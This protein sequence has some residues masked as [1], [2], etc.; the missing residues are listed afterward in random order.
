MAALGKKYSKVCNDPD[1]TDIVQPYMWLGI[2]SSSSQDEKRYS[3]GIKI[4]RIMINP[5]RNSQHYYTC[6]MKNCE[7][8]LE[9]NKEEPIEIAETGDTLK[10][11]RMLLIIQN[12]QAMKDVKETHVQEC[13][14]MVLINEKR[15]IW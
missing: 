8:F 1:K 10:I 9:T 14:E 3:I 13:K 6:K 5:K 7:W 15:S 2:T 4:R 11:V 12:G